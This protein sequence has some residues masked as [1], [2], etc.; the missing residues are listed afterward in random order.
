MVFYTSRGSYTSWGVQLI[1]VLHLMVLYTS[2]TQC[3]HVRVLNHVSTFMATNFTGTVITVGVTTATLDAM[4]ASGMDVQ[5][6]TVWVA[7]VCK[8]T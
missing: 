7:Q 6:Q 5:I 4:V 8:G 3:A 2:F 1:Q